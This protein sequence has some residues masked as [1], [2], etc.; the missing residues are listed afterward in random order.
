MMEKMVENV[1]TRCSSA[2]GSDAILEEERLRQFLS[3]TLASYRHLKAKRQK[4]KLK[5][6]FVKKLEAS[7]HALAMAEEEAEAVPASDPLEEAFDAALS[8]EA[9]DEGAIVEQA[10][11]VDPDIPERDLPPHHQSVQT[12]VS[13][14]ELR[15]QHEVSSADIGIGALK[16][17]EDIPVASLAY[18]L[19]RILFNP[20]VHWLQDPRTKYYNYSEALQ[21]IPDTQEFDFE[22]LPLF[23]KP[24]SD[25]NLRKLLENSTQKFAGSTSSLT[26]ALSQIYYTLNGNKPLNTQ[27]Q[28]FIDSPRSFSPGARI[29][30]SI[31]LNRTA[32]GKYIVDAD[33]AMDNGPD[34]PLSEKGHILEKMLTNPPEEFS[35]F[36][37]ASK[38]PLKPEESRDKKEAYHFATVREG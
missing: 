8:E 5:S 19:E 26:G 12:G 13:H 21:S 24:S 15:H 25:P 37:K 7:E 22:R 36:L 16:P 11:P 28:S 23:M 30:K 6:D 33:K 1:I 14:V 18:G 38:N 2:S 17:L 29:P 31:I 3:T 10:S 35:R 9:S 4:E 27:F 34:N 20:G 32:E